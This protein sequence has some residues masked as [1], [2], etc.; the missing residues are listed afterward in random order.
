MENPFV[1]R[2]LPSRDNRGMSI[3]L[4]DVNDLIQ[5]NSEETYVLSVTNDESGTLRGMHMQRN[6]AAEWKLI[7]VTEGSIF[8]VVIDLRPESRSYGCAYTCSLSAFEPAILSIPRGFAHGYQTLSRNTKLLYALD[9]RHSTESASIFSPLSDQLKAIWPLPV[10]CI[11]DADR[12]GA[13]LPYSKISFM[14]IRQLGVD[15]PS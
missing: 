5:L 13:S 14:D 9:G 6:D 8:D 1:R 2:I 3:R 12:T 15:G 4:F 10:S 11:S 7:T